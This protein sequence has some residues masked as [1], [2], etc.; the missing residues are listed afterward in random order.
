MLGEEASPDRSGKKL[1]SF[2]LDEELYKRLKEYSSDSGQSM[3]NVVHNAL[4][5]FLGVKATRQDIGI[6]ELARIKNLELPDPSSPDDE[7]VRWIVSHTR[8]GVYNAVRVLIREGGSFRDFG[9]RLLALTKQ[10][11]PLK[12]Y[13]VLHAT[14]KLAPDVY[15]VIR[16]WES[17]EIQ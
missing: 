9:L 8:A 2:L 7:I 17:G 12:Y 15:D 6:Q 4:S 14:Q 13:F 10:Y 5:S 11:A 16:G 3:T 1:V